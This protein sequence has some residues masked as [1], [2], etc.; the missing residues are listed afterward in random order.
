VL[1]A[2]LHN[3]HIAILYVLAQSTDMS[4]DSD[5]EDAILPCFSDDSAAGNNIIYIYIYYIVFVKVSNVIST[6]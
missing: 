3:A 4:D 5:E 6:A 1:V 2:T